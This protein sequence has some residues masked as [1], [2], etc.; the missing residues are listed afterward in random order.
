MN[1]HLL[2]F[3][4]LNV[5]SINKRT[6]SKHHVIVQKHAINYYSVFT[7]LQLRKSMKSKNGF[8]DLVVSLFFAKTL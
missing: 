5:D 8:Q 1:S 3:T 4:L 6:I 2:R 7:T